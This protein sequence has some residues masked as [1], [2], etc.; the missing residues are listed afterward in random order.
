MSALVAALVYFALVG[1][2]VWIVQY[3]D[4]LAEGR[5]I[6]EHDR[7]LEREREAESVMIR[8]RLRILDANRE[9]LELQEA[10]VYRL[11]NDAAS[12]E[13]PWRRGA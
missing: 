1:T 13:E 3:H 2:A 8:E 4:R 6:R 9:T 11:R 7:W 5:N 10:T 12:R